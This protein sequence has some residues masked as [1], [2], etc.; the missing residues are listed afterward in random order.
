MSNR[1]S[2]KKKA[3]NSNEVQEKKNLD[4]NQ[5]QNYHLI[6]PKINGKKRLIIDEL[7]NYSLSLFDALFID[8]QVLGQKINDFS[9]FKNLTQSII[10]KYNPNFLTKNL[11]NENK[12]TLEGKIPLNN[13]NLTYINLINIQNKD[14]VNISINSRIIKI[15]KPNRNFDSRNNFFYCTK[16]LFSGKHCFEMEFK[17]FNS[18]NVYIG[19]IDISKI[20]LLK[21]Y[22]HDINHFKKYNEDE[23]DYISLSREFFYTNK[24]NYKLN[25]YIKSG[26][27]I[28]LGFDL[29]YGAIYLFIDGELVLRETLNIKSGENISFAP[30]FT[31]SE[32]N[33]I[34]FNF[35]EDDFKF[36]KSYDSFNLISLDKKENNFIILSNLKETTDNLLQMIEQNLS[37]MILHN[38]I[39]YSDINYLFF[40]IFNFLGNIS[41][42]ENYL[43][44]NSLLKIYF[45]EIFEN[46]SITE[47]KLFNK[48]LPFQ[49]IL[50]GS[51]NIKKLTNNILL[52]IIEE[53]NLRLQKGKIKEIQVIH[54]LFSLLK[55]L[56]TKKLFKNN[57]IDSG[58]EGIFEIFRIFLTPFMFEINREQ[59]N[60]QLSFLTNINNL[61]FNDQNSS[62]YLEEKF[63]QIN[64]FLIDQRYNIIQY[65]KQ[66]NFFD[67]FINDVYANAKYKNNLYTFFKKFVTKIMD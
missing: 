8:R 54:N 9:S 46:K 26:D 44:N 63:K 37:K 48:Y 52:N 12:I 7:R 57:L 36:K 28:G 35:S 29:N 18:K 13:K 42:N 1:K 4:S 2:Q 25:R 64:E 17:S 47:E 32:G 34:L 19:L 14:A 58:E 11:S 45:H 56:L 67:F 16:A 23:L 55:F 60:D 6:T 66:M 53:I 24:N 61:S 39:S 15:F 65:Y 40:N 5:K 22:F 30:F 43:I 41:F 50:N 38:S 59:L 51:S 3:D 49:C 62:D 10:K 20:N 27:T 33:N 31:L 21:F